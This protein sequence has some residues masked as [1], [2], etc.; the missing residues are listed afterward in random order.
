MAWG[1]D[2]A[3]EEIENG[4]QNFGLALDNF[5]YFVSTLSVWVLKVQDVFRTSFDLD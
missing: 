4:G 2:D 5:G 3:E 1:K